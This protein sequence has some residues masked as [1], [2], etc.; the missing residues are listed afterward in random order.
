MSVSHIDISVVNGKHP[1]SAFNTY[2]LGLRKGD[3]APPWSRFDAIDCPAVLPWI[4]LLKPDDEGGLFYAIS[5][6]GCDRVFGLTYQGLK[7][8]EGMPESAVRD[9]QAEFDRTVEE[10]SPLFSRVQ[11]P[12]KDKEHVA[13][14]R[15]V[16]PF[17]SKDSDLEAIVVVIAPVD[18]KLM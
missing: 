15:G 5:G 1:I 17:L 2:W 8:G 16:F 7:F 6:T 13:V 14:F 18:I 10:R 12:V 3:E 9:R 11:L 4:L